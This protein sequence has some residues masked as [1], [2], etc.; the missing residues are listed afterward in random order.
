MLYGDAFGSSTPS[1]SLNVLALPAVQQVMLRRWANGDFIGDWDAN[2][3]PPHEIGDVPLA[4]QPAMLDQAAL[5][6]GPLSVS[7]PFIVI[8]DPIVSI[9]LSVWVFAEV[10]TE[11]A[12]RLTVGVAS[13]SVMCAAV[14]VLARTAPA[15]MDRGPSGSTSPPQGRR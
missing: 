1:S 5:H 13:F 2:T 7:Q 11:N 8:V 15:T 12:L 9:V 10:F 4:A 6:V 14:A 3:T